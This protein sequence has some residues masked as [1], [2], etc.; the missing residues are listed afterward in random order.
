MHRTEDGGAV[1]LRWVGH[2]PVTMS[3]DMS[4]RC[5][6]QIFDFVTP[7]EEIVEQHR[8]EYPAITAENLASELDANNWASAGTL[9]TKRTLQPS[10]ISQAVWLTAPPTWKPLRTSS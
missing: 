10:P 6:E 8:S 9:T 1:A 2:L 7:A 5:I 3:I 4:N